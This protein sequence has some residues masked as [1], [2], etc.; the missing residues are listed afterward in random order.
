MAV[1]AFVEHWFVYHLAHIVAVSASLRLFVLEIE[2]ATYQ[3]LRSKTMFV[4]LILSL[5]LAQHS[6]IC[7]IIGQFISIQ[8]LRNNKH[9]FCSIVFSTQILFGVLGLFTTFCSIS[10]SKIAKLLLFCFDLA[11][12]RSRSFLTFDAIK[13]VHRRVGWN[14]EL[15]WLFQ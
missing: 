15:T 13:L 11:T 14:H 5:L 12:S 8:L 6:S 7:C 2:Q 9:A 4:I 1:N 10:R 3:A